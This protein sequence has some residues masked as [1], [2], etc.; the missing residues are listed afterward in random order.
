M[1]TSIFDKVN[2]ESPKE[3]IQRLG[4]APIHKLGQNFLI[5]QQ[6]VHFII[7][8]A[9]IEENDALVEI[10]P[11]TGALTQYLS[12]MGLPLLCVEIDQ[13]LASYLKDT[14]T[15]DLVKIVHGDV[16]FK[17]RQL[18]ADLLEYIKTQQSEGRQLKF[19]SNLPYHILTPLLWNLL[20]LPGLDLRAMLM[21]QLEF[22][23]RLNASP[24]DKQYSPLGI[25][26]QNYCRFKKLRKLGKRI[27]WPAPG[28]DSALIQIF[29][30]ENEESIPGGYAEF[31]KCIFQNRRKSLYKVL[32]NNFANYDSEHIFSHFSLERGVRAEQLDHATLLGLFEDWKSQEASL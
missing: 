18:N 1:T 17:K 8:N 20:Q 5:D 27:F 4:F 16:L 24:G 23:D 6:M 2:W 28:V 22:A 19:I 13:G 32:K 10:G 9:N 7:G 29:P 3:I 15:T 30:R 25:L 11:G 21:V 31:L 26:M 12:Q 14:Y